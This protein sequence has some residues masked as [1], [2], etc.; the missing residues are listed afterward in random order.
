MQEH[1]KHIFEGEPDTDLIRA[2]E[3][4]QLVVAVHHPVPRRQLSTR[5]K[6][7]LWALRVFLLVISAAVIYTFV[8]G[9]VKGGG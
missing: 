3:P 5:V 9:V 8:V 7:G 6:V 2:L 1:R 4:D